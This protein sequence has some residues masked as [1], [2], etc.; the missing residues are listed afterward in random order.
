MLFLPE[1]FLH[2]TS[3]NLYAEYHDRHRKFARIAMNP[4]C[5]FRGHGPAN[6][7]DTEDFMK[8]EKSESKTSV[9]KSAALIQQNVQPNDISDPSIPFVNGVKEDDPVV[10]LMSKFLPPEVGDKFGEALDTLCPAL[11]TTP[12]LEDKALRIVLSLAHEVVMVEPEIQ[13]GLGKLSLSDKDIVGIDDV[14]HIFGGFMI[15]LEVDQALREGIE[16]DEKQM[17]TAGENGEVTEEM[18][19]Q[20]QDEFAH[21]RK[22]K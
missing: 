18:I 8:N 17:M 9:S 12:K 2:L 4:L 11:K 13:S 19:Q 3:V 7:E 5:C 14:V 22:K 10:F 20:W 16:Y 1:S 15:P 21:E 6:P